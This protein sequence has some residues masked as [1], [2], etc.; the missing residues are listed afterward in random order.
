MYL[1]WLIPFLILLPNLFWMLFPP[2]GAPAAE[3][4]E[5]SRFV[6]L[7]EVVEWIGRIGCLVIPLF[8]RVEVQSGWQIGALGVM[9]AALLLYYAGW[10]RYFVRRRARRLLFEPLLGVP[11]PLA[12]APIVWFLAA[13]VL[14]GSWPMAISA[15]VL[16]AGH[17]VL[18]Q[19]A[20]RA[21]GKRPP[22]G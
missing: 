5:R 6:R 18:T 2:R 15:L 7:M 21:L 4:V 13:A 1:G 14:L 8:F 10:A 17:L 19:Q 9:A 16:A 11:L 22:A 20:S 3:K 12:V